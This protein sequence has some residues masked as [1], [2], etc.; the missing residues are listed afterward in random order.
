[1]LH[2]ELDERTEESW[3]ERLAHKPDN[4]QHPLHHLLL[5]HCLEQTA[6]A[7]FHLPTEDKP[8]GTGPWPCLNP[9]CNHFRQFQI[10][11]C[12]IIYSQHIGGKPMGTFACSCGYTYSRTG[13]DKS[14]ND[15]F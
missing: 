12:H 3:L 11:E 6:E 4:A 9:A 10:K 1:M 15:H 7:F 14:V 13:P 2:C 8:F 5:I